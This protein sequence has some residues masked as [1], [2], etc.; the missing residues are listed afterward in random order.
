[1]KLIERDNQLFDHSLYQGHTTIYKNKYIKDLSLIGRDLSTIIII[2]NLEYSYCLQK[3]NGILIKPFQ[4]D[5]TNDRVLIDLLPILI[6]IAKSKGDIRKSLLKC[7][8]E[9]VNKV[10]LSNE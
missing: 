6:R 2:D 9:I 1:M 3:E 4:G 7:K 10:T 5:I 8:D